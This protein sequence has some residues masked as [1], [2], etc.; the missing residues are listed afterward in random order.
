MGTANHPWREADYLHNPS[1]LIKEVL[2]LHWKKIIIVFP[3]ADSKNENSISLSC[4]G[5]SPS[6]PQLL[7]ADTVATECIGQ[8]GSIPKPTHQHLGC[9]LNSH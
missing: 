2:I 3:A 4:G 8:E 6:G 7:L 9:E 5:P 1:S